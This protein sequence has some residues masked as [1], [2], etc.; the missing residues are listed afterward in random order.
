GLALG[1]VQLYGICLGSSGVLFV[2][3]VAGH[4]G[5]TITP[6][7]GTLGLVLFTY[8]VGLGAGGRF[9]SALRK[10]GQAL[11]LLALVVTGTAAFLTWA[12]A[13]LFAIPADLAVGLFAGALTSTPALAAA[14]DFLGP[15]GSGVMVGYVIA[16][17]VGVIAVVLFVQL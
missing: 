6:G 10:Q 8:S 7:V 5:Y 11:V 13:R 4:F 12:L 3:M 16:Y 2:A 17:P 14:A 15:A 9:F 1:K